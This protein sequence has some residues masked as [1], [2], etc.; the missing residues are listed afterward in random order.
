MDLGPS[1][2]AAHRSPRVQEMGVCGC[3]GRRLRGPGA[4]SS[5]GRVPGGRGS[6]PPEPLVCYFKDTS[7]VVVVVM[8]VIKE[9]R[10]L[11]GRTGTTGSTGTTQI[12]DPKTVS[13]KYSKNR[14]ALDP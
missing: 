4:I 12:N 7:P 11:A 14:M 6:L 9:A 3:G 8:E 5:P 2:G 1:Q 13:L 10:H